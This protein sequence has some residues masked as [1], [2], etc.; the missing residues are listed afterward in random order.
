MPALRTQSV[1]RLMMRWIFK[2]VGGLV[3]VAIV[4]AVLYVLREKVTIHRTAHLVIHGVNILDRDVHALVVDAIKVRDFPVVE[5]DFGTF[6]QNKLRNG[7]GSA[8]VV[9]EIISRP[10][11]VTTNDVNY[12]YVTIILPDKNMDRGEYF[13][14]SQSETVSVL[15]MY[16][17]G[18][19]HYPDGACF[20]YAYKGDV[21]VEPVSE[22]VVQVS[23]SLTF[24]LVEMF[25]RKLHSCGEKRIYL[26]AEFRQ[27]GLLEFQD[28]KFSKFWDGNRDWWLRTWSIGWCQENPGTCQENPG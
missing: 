9:R 11:S 10:F 3:A 18:S 1:S 4:L 23:A 27:I 8:I 25:G 19:A 28:S 5:D 14:R 21:H 17:S 7:T 2:A 15:A 6:S 12:E 13:V 22:G 26:K 16:A 24:D 20:G